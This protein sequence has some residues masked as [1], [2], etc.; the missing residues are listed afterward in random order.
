MLAVFEIV[1]L[2]GWTDSMYNIRHAHKNSMVFDSFFFFVV[3]FG[4]F[5]V[6]NLMTA[7]QFNYFE[8]LSN[9]EKKLKQAKI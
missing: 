6:L 4:T 1:T 8:H 7:V 3:V 2:E 5:F 9:K